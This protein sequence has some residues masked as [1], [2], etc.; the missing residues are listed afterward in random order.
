MAI[1]SSIIIEYNLAFHLH[2]LVKQST[3]QKE[4]LLE[5]CQDGE[6]VKHIF[7]L[8]KKDKEL[9]K[10]IQI[11]ENG[12]LYVDFMKA[13]FFQ[14]PSDFQQHYFDV[15]RQIMAKDTLIDNPFFDR[16]F[17]DFDFT[18]YYDTWLEMCKAKIIFETATRGKSFNEILDMLESAKAADENVAIYY[19]GNSIYSKLDDKERAYLKVYGKTEDEYNKTKNDESEG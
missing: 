16:Y 15:T 2:E 7:S 8:Q 1:K 17:K 3:D 6:Y 9:P 14:L 19:Q 4:L 5:I 18:E 13:T 12:V 10:Y 11:G